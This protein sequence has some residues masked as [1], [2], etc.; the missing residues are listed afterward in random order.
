M[1]RI[2]RE[3]SWLTDCLTFV[4]TQ[5]CVPTWVTKILMRAISN[6]PQAADSPSLLYLMRMPS[7]KE[8]YY[9]SGLVLIVTA[10]QDVC[11]RHLL[12]IATVWHCV[13]QKTDLDARKRTQLPSVIGREGHLSSACGVSCC[14]RLP[15]LSVLSFLLFFER[16]LLRQKRTC[17]KPFHQNPRFSRLVYTVGVARMFYRRGAIV[18]FSGG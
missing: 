10:K 6:G 16:A 8:V 4:L 3:F 7:C 14:R 11:R 13:R 5:C 18:D 2:E 17:S 9:C 12:T 15:C 1:L